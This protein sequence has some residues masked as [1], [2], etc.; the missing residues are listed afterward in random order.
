M[1]SSGIASKKRPQHVVV[2]PTDQEFPLT[3]VAKVDKL[4][5]QATAEP[6]I[7][8]LRQEGRWD[9]APPEM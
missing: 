3:R 9:A 5:L 4:A 6:M 1:T 7:A 8:Q 2:W